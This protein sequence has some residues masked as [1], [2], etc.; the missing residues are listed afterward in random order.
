MAGQR[1]RPQRRRPQRRRY[2][3][4]VREFLN[5]PGWHGNAYVVAEVVDTSRA[6]VAEG[7]PVLPRTRLNIADCSNECRFEFDLH[8]LAGQ[9]NSLHKVETLID[10][11]QRFREGLIAEIDLCNERTLTKKKEKKREGKA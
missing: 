5:L 10:A 2:R 11:L 7:L 1:R 6:S 8:T 3:V 4:A 9:E